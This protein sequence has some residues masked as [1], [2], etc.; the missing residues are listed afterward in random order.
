MIIKCF[1]F[2]LMLTLVP[3]VILPI[4]PSNGVAENYT[5][6]RLPKGAKARLGKGSI[7]DIAYSPDD[8]C[9]AVAGSLGIWIYDAQSGD[10]NRP[11][12]WTSRWCS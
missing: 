3:A 11:T 1:S 12:H 2:F 5:Q 7:S 9:L 10:E 6:I 8:K 4:L